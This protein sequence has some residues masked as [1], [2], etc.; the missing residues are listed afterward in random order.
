MLNAFCKLIV[1]GCSATLKIS[2]SSIHLEDDGTCIKITDHIYYLTGESSFG[3]LL[4]VAALKTD[5]LPL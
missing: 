1:A 2:N 3:V 5:S 4:T